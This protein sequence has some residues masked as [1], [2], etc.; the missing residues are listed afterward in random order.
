MNEGK[1]IS[2]KD[3]MDRLTEIKNNLQNQK[4]K[5]T[6]ISKAAACLRDST[7]VGCLGLSGMGLVKIIGGRYRWI[8][9]PITKK[10]AE[11]FY[12]LVNE[13]RSE[14]RIKKRKSVRGVSKLKVNNEPDPHIDL[15]DEIS[16]AVRDRVREEFE[17][18]ETTL[19]CI[20][21][22][23]DVIATKANINLS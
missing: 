18:I 2:L 7:S 11:R 17:P 23:M 21:R 20:Q 3:K 6:N 14:S 10:M 8:G 9:G 4:K 1:N 13:R 22:H 15:A 16:K 19:Q 5:Y 12:E